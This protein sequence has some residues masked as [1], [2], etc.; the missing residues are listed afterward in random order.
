MALEELE[1][2][3][4][5]TII[6]KFSNT[7]HETLFKASYDTLQ[8]HIEMAF[9]CGACQLNEK[10]KRSRKRL[11]RRLGWWSTLSTKDDFISE[12]AFNELIFKIDVND[13]CI[14]VSVDSKCGGLP[15]F[16][17]WCEQSVKHFHVNQA[18]TYYGIY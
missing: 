11:W 12:G 10:V 15:H 16:K 6:F 17:E 9:K 7:L 8:S 5:K 4:Q 2:A 13:D 14:T 1:D 18:M 3:K